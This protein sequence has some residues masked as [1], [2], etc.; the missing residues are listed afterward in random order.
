MWQEKDKSLF[1]EFAI[2]TIGEMGL[3][4]SQIL[5]G[6]D[7]LDEEKE[8]FKTMIMLADFASLGFGNLGNALSYK[9]LLDEQKHLLSEKQLKHFNEVAKCLDEKNYKKHKKMIKIV[10]RLVDS[11]RDELYKKTKTP[12]RLRQENIETVFSAFSH[13]IHG[14]LILLKDLLSTNRPKNRN[15]LRI[16]W[17]LLITG[18]NTLTHVQG[19]LERKGIKLKVEDLFDRFD[20]IAKNLA[21]YWKSIEK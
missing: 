17:T 2:R 21:K 19:F 15:R 7:L 9:K 10:R 14:N 11:T 8:K 3:K 5:Y 6:S 16:T 13:L 18:V 4:D 20:L 1:R 12:G